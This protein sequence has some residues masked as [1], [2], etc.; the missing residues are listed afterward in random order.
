MDIIAQN[1]NEKAAIKSGFQ[2]G[3]K[4]RYLLWQI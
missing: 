3:Q 1:F 4:R 2:K